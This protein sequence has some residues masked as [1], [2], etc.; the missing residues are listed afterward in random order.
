MNFVLALKTVGRLRRRFSHSVVWE[1]IFKGA[2]AGPSL[3]L[4]CPLPSKA[5]FRLLRE[6]AGEVP[7]GRSWIPCILIGSIL[8]AN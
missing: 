1:G 8:D 6:I 2:N 7:H 3:S 4:P 5:I